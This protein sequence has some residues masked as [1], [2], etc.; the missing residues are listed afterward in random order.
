MFRYLILFFVLDFPVVSWAQVHDDIQTA[1]LAPPSL[2]LSAECVQGKCT[3]GVKGPPTKV[4]GCIIRKG[5]R[6]E[7]G[8]CP[9]GHVIIGT[10]YPIPQCSVHSIRAVTTHKT[11]VCFRPE[12]VYVLLCGRTIV[13]STHFERFSTIWDLISFEHRFAAQRYC[14][15]RS[16]PI[17]V[18]Q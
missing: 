13:K 10:A 18:Q 7:S 5:N 15:V 12:D 1:R 4:T 11:V 6:Y 8:V 9:P 17:I 3:V 14:L 2:L 16:K